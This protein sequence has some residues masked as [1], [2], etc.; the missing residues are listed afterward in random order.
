MVPDLRISEACRL[1]AKD[2]DSKQ[3]VIHIRQG[4]RGKDRLVPMSPRMLAALRSYWIEG[5]AVGVLPV[6]GPALRP[7]H[8]EGLS[9]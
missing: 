2:I 4:K 8:F 5:E 9:S 3:M 1:R 7:T 6:P